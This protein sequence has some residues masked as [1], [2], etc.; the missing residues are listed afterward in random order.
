MSAAEVEDLL[1]I[2]FSVSVT[3]LI[4]LSIPDVEEI[5]WAD[6]TELDF[7]SVVPFYLPG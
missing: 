7:E 1:A 3:F 2:C 6:C 5:G 4:E